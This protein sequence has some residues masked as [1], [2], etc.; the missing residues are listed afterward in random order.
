MHHGAR[1]GQGTE[2]CEEQV[3]TFILVVLEDVRTM[4]NKD[5][6]YKHDMCNKK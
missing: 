4:D 2:E 5:G 3:M 6:A 1:Q